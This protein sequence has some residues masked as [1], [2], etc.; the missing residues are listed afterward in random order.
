MFDTEFTNHQNVPCDRRNGKLHNAPGKMKGLAPFDIW[1]RPIRTDQQRF[2]IRF[3]AA[4]ELGFPGDIEEF[5]HAYNTGYSTLNQIEQHRFVYN[6]MAARFNQ[7][8]QSIEDYL[9]AWTIGKSKVQK[10]YEKEVNRYLSIIYDPECKDRTFTEYL[11][12]FTSF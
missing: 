12:G 10:N 4:R 3:D 5:K 9:L 7:D 6:F 1:W 8:R 2:K 11:S